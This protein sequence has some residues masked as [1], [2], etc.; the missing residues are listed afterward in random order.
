MKKSITLNELLYYSGFIILIIIRMTFAS[1]LVEFDNTTKNIL[2]IIASFLFIL[3]ICLDSTY[4]SKR[5]SI[6][7]CF[8]FFQFYFLIKGVSMFIFTSA[9]AVA[10]IKG[11]DIKKIVKIDLIIKIIFLL[12]HFTLFG[13]DYL[14]DVTLISNN[15]L[16]TEKGLAYSLYFKN[17]NNASAFVTWM[18]IDCIYL[19]R[20]CSI[21]KI[22][23][24][25]PVVYTIYKI[26]KC[27]TSI[28]IYIGALIL[29][30]IKNK[31]I[32][33]FLFRYSY[34][35]IF[36]ISMIMMM[37]YSY[38]TN[39]F[40]FFNHLLSGRL[41]FSKRALDIYG[42][43]FLPRTSGD[44]LFNNLVIDN[45]FFRCLIKFGILFLMTVGVP[46]FFIKREGFYKEKVYY[47]LGIVSLFFECV[48]IDV[49]YAIP[50]LFVGYIYFFGGGKAN[51]E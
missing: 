15:I 42:S 1:T 17:P 49:G 47:V 14:F 10:S 50:F 3:K 21:K 6:L 7:F 2:T 29:Y 46:I 48:I 18:I 32:I 11:I 33:N 23:L 30:S 27:R 24:F 5:N 28:F 22:L 25:L 26:T 45:Y 43:T 31:K 37:M 41:S 36:G 19:M 8:L 35:L 44:P 51:D 38:N 39:L 34:W 13:I 20:K 40:D 9:L 12:I 4:F 16:S